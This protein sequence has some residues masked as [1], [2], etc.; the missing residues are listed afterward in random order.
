MPGLF[1]TQEDSFTIGSSVDEVFH[2][3]EGKGRVQEIVQFPL[4]FALR[5]GIQSRDREL[6]RHDSLIH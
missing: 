2:G 6:S 1:S 3:A 5:G 4:K